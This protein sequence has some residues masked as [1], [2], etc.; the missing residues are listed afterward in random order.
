MPLRDRSLPLILALIGALALSVGAGCFG[1]SRLDKAIVQAGMS[2]ET[3]YPLAGK[4]TVDWLPPALE[5]RETLVAMLNDP[6]KLDRPVPEKA[7]TVVDPKTGAFAFTT[8]ASRD[9]IKAG[10]YI[11]T[12][13]VLSSKGKIGLV[14]P[15]KLHNLYNDP[16][17]NS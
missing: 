7:Y 16:D 4:V 11:L 2:K 9:G 5:R 12:F 14:G 15:D 17:K 13:A 6:Q 8:Y 10:N 3:V 1:Q